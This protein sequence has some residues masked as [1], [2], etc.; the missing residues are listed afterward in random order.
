MDNTE[1]KLQKL[2][3]DKLER[4][5]KESNGSADY[6]NGL[7]DGE[8]KAIE[9]I[10]GIHAERLDDHE[11]AFKQHDKRIL[12]QERVVYTLIAAAALIRF[13]PELRDLIHYAD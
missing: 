7:R 9:T 8:L 2:V 5:R 10:L 4:F 11:Q 3:K 12:M 1:A 13:L 6:F